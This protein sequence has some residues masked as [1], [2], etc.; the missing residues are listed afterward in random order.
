MPKTKFF[1][2]KMTKSLAVSNSIIKFANPTASKPRVLLLFLR[3][4]S[5]ETES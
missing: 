5:A 2:E 3:A 1:V 4:K